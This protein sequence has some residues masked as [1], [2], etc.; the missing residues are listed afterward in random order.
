MLKGFLMAGIIDLFKSKKQEKSI[1]NHQ[2]IFKSLNLN[3]MNK[4]ADE[5]LT[6]KEPEV[7]T[8]AKENNLACKYQDIFLLTRDNNISIGIE[9]KG[10]SYSALSL[11][12]E[13]SFL[14]SRISF[15]QKLSSEIELKIIIKKE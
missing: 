9:L 12:N 11:E 13:L 3:Q 7:F 2:N 10:A 5:I 8:L 4:V 6:L 14:D 15:L 1:K